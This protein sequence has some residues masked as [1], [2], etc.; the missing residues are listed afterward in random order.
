VMGCGRM[1][2]AL[3]ALVGLNLFGLGGWG[4]GMWPNEFGPTGIGG[5][6]FVWPRWL[7]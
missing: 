3:R 1:N 5:M 6:E 2:S 7:G 4:D